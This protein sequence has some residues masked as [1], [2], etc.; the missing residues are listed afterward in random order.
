MNHDTR[1][2]LALPQVG[3][4]ADPAAIVTVATAAEAAGYSSLWALDRL[5]APVHPR[6]PYPATPDGLLPAEQYTVLDPIGALTLAATVTERIRVG[7][8]VLVAPWYAPVVL[9]R[10][11]TTLDHISAG[12]LTVGLGLGWSVDEYEAVGVTQ[13]RLAGHS[14]EILDVLDATWTKSV[15]AHRGERYHIAP[16]TVLPKPVQKPRPPLLLAAYTPAGLDR[17]A[18]RADGWI[19]AG[20]PVEAVAPMFAAVREMAATHGRSPDALELV[21]RANIKITADAIAGDRPSYW[22]SV[23][24]IAEDLDATR[25]AGA[26]EIILDLHS[27]VRTGQGLLE[28]AAELTSRLVVAV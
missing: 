2:G 11:L 20:L 16:S 8:S 12:R 24:Q 21:V 26:H 1:I 22:G 25:A 15:V 9:A 27:N 23:D 4:L 18:R 14:E 13:R 7:T 3:A 19:P 6:T 28:L 5:L 10:T 17:V